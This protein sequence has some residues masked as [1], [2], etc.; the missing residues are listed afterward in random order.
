MQTSPQGIDCLTAREG[1]R[2]DAYQDT[3][4]IW[5]I[6]VGHTAASGLPCPRAGMTI[7]RDEAEAI[8]ARD[9][10]PCEA[11]VNSLHASLTQAQFDALVSFAFNIGTA[12]FL[13]S[14]CARRLAVGDMDGAARA[15]TL[16]C[17]P[18]EI[19]ARRR[20]EIRQFLTGEY[21]A[22]A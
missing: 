18:P 21:T 14:T 20:G 17:Y 10:I 19:A 7:T 22:R 6:G 5:T 8:L 15:M 12:G 16:W 4:G 13:R 11:A 1:V 3:R 2:L 9:V